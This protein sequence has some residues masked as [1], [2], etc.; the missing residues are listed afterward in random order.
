LHYSLCS[1]F[2]PTGDD[3]FLYLVRN[4]T[5]DDID[6][7]DF[8]DFCP[9][10]T[11]VDSDSDSDTKTDANADADEEL[12]D[13]ES[14]N[15]NEDN[16]SESDRES[17]SESESESD[18]ECENGDKSLSDKY[19]H[20]WIQRDVGSSDFHMEK[21]PKR[22]PLTDFF[23]ENERNFCHM[24]CVKTE[25]SFMM[26]LDD[27]QLVQPEIEA[28]S[29]LFD[30]CRIFFVPE[31]CVFFR[32]VGV[33][34]AC[35]HW[36]M[37]PKEES[38]L[39]AFSKYL[40]VGP[41]FNNGIIISDPNSSKELNLDGLSLS[42][43]SKLK[44]GSFVHNSVI[45]FFPDPT[46]FNNH[47]G[48]PPLPSPPLVTDSD[49]TDDSSDASADY[50]SSS[51]ETDIESEDDSP[52]LKLTKKPKSPITKNSKSSKS[53][54]TDRKSK[55]QKDSKTSKTSKAKKPK[56]NKTKRS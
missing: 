2:S 55:T 6:L 21:L 8:K 51:A 23:V 4:E 44:C 1:V 18:D 34:F 27:P 33:P 46:R 12:K 17:E 41:S 32:V 5:D 38:L 29:L 19:L 24:M 43:W 13:Y 39:N 54:K 28:G 56:Q 26:R 10:V 22:K 14:D 3:A 48:K 49:S 35:S 15:D 16:D 42:E 25:G 52:P 53:S 47:F 20:V 30:N 31:D 40:G 36:I 37:P 50:S 7:D 11:S 9:S 45:H